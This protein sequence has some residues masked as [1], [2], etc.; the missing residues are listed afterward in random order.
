MNSWQ[1][2]GAVLLAIALGVGL[3]GLLPGYSE[4]FG[5][6]GF[7]SKAKITEVLRGILLMAPV[8][9]LIHSKLML[10]IFVVLAAVLASVGGLR[11]ISQGDYIGYFSQG[12]V[13]ANL[14]WHWPVFIASVLVLCAG[15]GFNARRGKNAI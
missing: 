8:A 7:W 13:T 9:L 2:T 14:S 6:G 4:P 15:F 12:A 3:A 11:G 1:R 5:G 10:C